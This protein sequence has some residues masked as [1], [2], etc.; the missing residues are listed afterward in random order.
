[1]NSFKSG[2]VGIFGKPNAGKSSL[3]NKLLNQKLS[4]V[5]PKVQTTRNKI[6][7]ILTTDAYQIV[8][9]D[10]PGL[11]QSHYK[12][13]DKMQKEIDDAKKG[14]DI[15]M[16]VMD[17]TDDVEENLKHAICLDKKIPLFFI[18]NKIDLVTP[19]KL[20]AIQ[21]TIVEKGKIEYIFPLSVN[22]G[23]GIDILLNKIIDT[24]PASPPYYQDDMV[25]NRSMR[26]FSA[27]IIREKI[28]L[29]VHEEIPYHSAVIITRYEEKKNITHIEADI[30]VS[31][32]S[33]K[34]ILLGKKGIMIQTIAE[35][36]R[37]ELEEWVEQKVFLKLFI[38][39][40]K[41]WRNNELYLKEYGY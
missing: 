19:E 30:I 31:R 34:A 6:E 25:S 32:E 29:N 11:L 23:N 21:N 41:D 28:F 18:I 38:K 33:Q 37:K 26:F 40:R 22:N 20:M 36:A 7:G 17:A 24:L 12:L 4:I 27:E 14:L 3:L 39:V 10:T 1:M 15:Q 9:A 8:F 13:H 35:A 2:F 5:S 16:F